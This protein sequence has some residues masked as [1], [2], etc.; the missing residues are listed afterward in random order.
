SGIDFNLTANYN[1]FN[2]TMYNRG[3][4]SS[5]CEG[6][7][8]LK[9]LHSNREI[10]CVML[11]PSCTYATFQ[12]VDDEIGLS[13]SIP[14]IS[15]GSFG[16]SCNYKSKL[17]RILPPARKIS[18]LLIHFVGEVLPFKPKWQNAYVYRKSVEDTT[19]D[20][21]WYINALEAASA[22]FARN[23]TR[24]MLR[25]EDSLRDVLTTTQRHS[26]IFI[27]CGSPNDVVSVKSKL[28]SPIIEET[29]FILLDVY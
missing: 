9:M 7:A 15:A 10:G 23:V 5:T 25:T 24:Q 11:G 13:L 26:N 2:T 19:E 16:L 27:L 3:C 12:L 20:C 22:N 21:F 4:G 1:G 6:V 18:D 17:T 29:L 14:V 28:T 8:I